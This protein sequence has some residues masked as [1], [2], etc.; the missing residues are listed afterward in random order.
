[1]KA[2]ACKTY[3]D[4]FKV[5]G[6]RVLFLVDDVNA[7]KALIEYNNFCIELKAYEQAREAVRESVN[8]QV[9]YLTD[10]E[11]L[12]SEQIALVK[13]L[14]LCNRSGDDLGYYAETDN[15]LPFSWSKKQC[16]LYSKAEQM[17]CSSDAKVRE[18]REK[19]KDKAV[20][21]SFLLNY[22]PLIVGVYRDNN[23]IGWYN[24]PKAFIIKQD[25]Y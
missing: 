4:N 10:E 19:L 25:I 2:L 24:M 23:P 18:E 6:T 20:P 21:M 12:S 15:W 14:N 16:I 8:K 3:D 13:E 1:M 7:K 17:R 22:N 9:P 5:N 11:L